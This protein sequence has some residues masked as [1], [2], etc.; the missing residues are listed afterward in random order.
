MIGALVCGLFILSACQSV[1]GVLVK[2]NSN[3]EIAEKIIEQDDPNIAESIATKFSEIDPDQFDGEEETIYL[4]GAEWVKFYEDD[5]YHTSKSSQWG[6]IGKTNQI[7]QFFKLKY[8]RS[9]KYDWYSIIWTIQVLSGHVAYNNDWRTGDIRNWV[10]GDRYDSYVKLID[11]GP[12]STQGQTTIGFNIGVEAGTSGAAVTAG[13]SV[14]YT[15]S[16]INVHD[17]T[18]F[19]KQQAKWWHDTNEGTI[20][21]D[22][23]ITIKPAAVFRVP[24]GESMKLNFTTKV[25]F[26]TMILGVVP[27]KWF[28]QT[29]WWPMSNIYKNYPPETPEKPSGPTSGTEDKSYEYSARAVDPDWDDVLYK[30]DWDDGTS[31]TSYYESDTTAKARH[32]WADPDTYSVQVKAKDKKGAW[33]DWSHI[34][35]VDIDEDTSISKQLSSIFSKIFLTNFFNTFKNLNQI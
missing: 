11:Y 25:S 20:G 19:S 13:I 16:D 14:S 9:N 28:H 34:L 8:D 24:Q 32:T 22:K 12:F 7:I 21:W 2:T 1:V 17:E 29:L 31:E 3:E 33:S 10:D 4:D 35:S 23:V 5:W 6:K 18:D 26:C 27:D 30:F 15:I